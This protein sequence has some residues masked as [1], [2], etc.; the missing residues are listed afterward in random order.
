MR[1][2]VGAAICLQLGVARAEPADLVTQ[3]L[4]LDVGALHARLVLERNVSL[5]SQGAPTSLAP[6]LW[7]GVAPRWQVGLVHSHAA[8]GLLETGASLCVKQDPYGCDRLYRGGGIE[9]RW[10]WKQGAFAVAPRGGLIAR[11]VEPWKPAAIGGAAVRWTRGR[12][13]ITSDPYL[14]IGLASRGL[15]NRDALVIP[16]WF[17]MQPSCRWTVAVRTGVD[18]ELATW[19]DGWHVPFALAVTARPPAGLE[20][21]IELG[22]QSLLGPQ[23]S[24]KER[25]LQM[26]VGWRGQVW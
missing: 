16:V 15:G 8:L 5:R 26:W 14:R 6:D 20:V 1:L 25:A 9:A 17:A 13:G 24:Y 18:G 2:F 19:K 23:N 22:F 4:V 10:S 21:G 7:V 3:P 12:F 11:D